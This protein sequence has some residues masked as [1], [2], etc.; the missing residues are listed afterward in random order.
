MT[1]RDPEIRK[2]LIEAAARIV[3]EEGSAA[4]STRRLAEEVG[5]S[6][7]AV[8]TYFSGMGELQRAVRR[9]GFDRLAQRLGEVTPSKDPL[10]EIAALG[11]AYVDVALSNPDLYRF[12]F[13]ETP[14]EDD[15]ATGIA[16]FE[17]VVQALERAKRAGRLSRGS[18]ELVARECW[19]AVHGG[20]SL[21]LVGMLKRDE[22][23]RA[24]D[25]LLA[26]IL[27]AYM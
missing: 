14:W 17:R 26:H 7:M 21:A 10:A 25:D 19:V 20:V 4:L 2:R 9:E 11:D 12:M 13:M 6:T 3:K 27:E 24:L 15:L 5:T 16:T 22:A 1:Q 8:Y 18:P 23:V